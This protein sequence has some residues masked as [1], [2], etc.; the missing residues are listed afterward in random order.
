MSGDQK[1]CD[2]CGRPM[3]GAFKGVVLI[4]MCT[5]LA[6]LAPPA[7]VDVWPAPGLN[8]RFVADLPHDH[9]PKPGAPLPARIEIVV[10]TTAATSQGETV[11]PPFR[12]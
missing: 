11:A 2:H 8:D 12:F 6:P 3:A 4:C 10:T 1:V 7:S 5:L 9:T